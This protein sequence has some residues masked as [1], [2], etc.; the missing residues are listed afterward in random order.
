MK[1]FVIDGNK[2]ILAAPS[3]TEHVDEAM[4]RPNEVYTVDIALTKGSG[5]TRD[6]GTRTT[7]YR[8]NLE[9]RYMVKMKASRAVLS[10]VDRRFPSFPFSCRALEEKSTRLGVVEL[11][12][13]EL[14]EP[15]PVI[16][17][18]DR[19]VAVHYKFTVLLTLNGTSRI[20]GETIDLAAYPSEKKVED[21]EILEILKQS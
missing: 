3:S 6:I 12:N 5:K 13:H 8:R 21:A 15:Y 14:L 1:Q 19:E 18:S 7:V 2:V 4:F 20:S 16:Y 17:T 9:S 10:E 11:V